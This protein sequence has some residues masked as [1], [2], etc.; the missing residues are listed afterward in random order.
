MGV[1]HA[2]FKKPSVDPLILLG[3]KDVRADREVVLIAINEFEGKHGEPNDF[4]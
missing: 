3:R 2:C 4:T 1:S